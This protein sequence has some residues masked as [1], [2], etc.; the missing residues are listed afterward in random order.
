MIVIRVIAQVQAEKRQDF[1]QFMTNFIGV[2]SKYEG[3]IKF[4]FYDDVN[5]ENTF[6]LYEE[7]ESLTHFNAY[8]ESEHFKES[9]TV[10]FPMMNGTP[11]SVYYEA[12][13][14]K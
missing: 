2:S 9:G 14:I 1:V 10:L 6:L 5:N 13:P 4:N 12:Q 11:D 3:C 8:R 7:W